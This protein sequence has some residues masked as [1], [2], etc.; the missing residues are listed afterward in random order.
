[1]AKVAL[2]I[3][4]SG[5][6]KS[7]SIEN[8]NEKITYLI[9]ADKKSL[10]FRGADQKY[11]IENLNYSRTS[12]VETI[13]KTLKAISDDAPHIKV[14][15]IDTANGIMNDKEM[16]ER[17]QKSFDKW[18]DLAG[19][20]WDITNICN[21]L[22]ENMIVYIMMHEDS[23]RNDSGTVIERRAKTNGRKLEKLVVESKASIVLFTHVE[24]E[25]GKESEYYF[26]TQGAG[27][28]TGKSPKGMF[29][30][31]KIANDLQIVS[32]AI[33]AYY[34]PKKE[35]KEEVQTKK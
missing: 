21:D 28:S 24:H 2:I 14:A 22:R 33:H 26:L 1:M 18:M 34:S 3:G 19:D 4:P 9:N 35:V 32:K 29:K 5:T 6:G 7:A 12:D 30:E 13:K 8:L 31:Y 10:P 17:K 25:P 20:I 23:T 16:S 15:I 11:S 27:I